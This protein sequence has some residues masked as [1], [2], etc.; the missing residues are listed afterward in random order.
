MK[1]IL[2]LSTFLVLLL[3]NNSF[4]QLKIVKDNIVCTYGIKNEQGNWV[5]EP[6]FILIEELQN[7]YFKTLTEE[8]KGVF[9]LTKQII[10]NEYD[11][12]S[13]EQSNFKVWKNNKV[14]ILSS[15]GE[16]IVPVIFNSLLLDMNLFICY[17][18]I[19]NKYSFTCIS[20]T[21]NVLIPETNGIIKP[22]L[23]QPYTLI[24]DQHFEYSANGNA[25]LIGID[26]KMLIPRIY[27]RLR[28]CNNVLT[29]VKD[30]KTGV[31]NLKNELILEG[32]PFLMP[33]AY[34]NYNEIPC[35]ESD[36][37]Y[38]FLENGKYG[39][40]KG[41][42][43]I[44]HDAS[45]DSIG[46]VFHEI[47]NEKTTYIYKYK[48]KYGF[49]SQN[50]EITTPAIYEQIIPKPRLNWENDY[51]KKK[52]L[53][54]LVLKNNRYGIVGDDGKEQIS[55]EYLRFYRLDYAKKPNYAISKWNEV[56]YL[57]FEKDTLKLQKMTL[58]NEGKIIDLYTFKNEYFAYEVSKFENGKNIISGI[59]PLYSI[60][61]FIFVT[62]ENKNHLYT[63]DGKPWTKYKECYVNHQVGKYALIQ[64]KVNSQGLLDLNTG[65]IILD[66]NFAEISQFHYASNVLWAKLKVGEEQIKQKRL[67]YNQNEIDLNPI[68]LNLEDFYTVP[69]YK[70]TPFDTLGNK[71]TSNLFDKALYSFDSSA[72]QN[73]SY[74]GVIDVNFN[75]L[76]PPIYKALHKFSK[77]QFLVY[78]KG[79]KYGIVNLKNELILDTIYTDF[80]Q[81][82]TG[83]YS[84][85]RVKTPEN[86]QLNQ[87][88]IWFRF[89]NESE[90]FILNN[91][92]LKIDSKNVIF[93]DKLLE[94]ALLGS[95]N[96]ELNAFKLRLDEKHLSYSDSI[97]QNKDFKMYKS[98]VFDYFK[99]IY[100][101][102][103]PCNFG[104][105]H[106]INTLP[107]QIDC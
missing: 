62:R 66:T 55:C 15:S 3:S 25:G 32:K 38:K 64:S 100:N 60:G 58:I 10:P 41:N 45:I 17:K 1:S 80:E 86:H 40:M 105:S 92:G 61:R 22:F 53:F 91:F 57:D 12:I 16:I 87:N 59:L 9:Y 50:G 23:G 107:H 101:Q 89:K 35:I 43:E 95:Q 106:E 99:A 76:V 70:W 6:T 94:L 19:D 39:I 79:Q 42:G 98:S 13:N 93:K 103:K 85:W 84:N 104:N 51:A 90:E 65:K 74:W 48:G 28:L 14:G 47:S 4:S 11:E 83:F 68:N 75:W 69:K 31:I 77:D 34:D 33:M 56:F 24:G 49:I 27:D 82:F 88:E 2:L 52:K 46:R 81:L 26:G 67:V 5:L 29:F 36:A 102:S 37:I 20:N 7:D 18:V 8:G 78:T 73:D 54:F 44:L 30:S 63:L 21:G 96:A 72:V 71:L 97:L